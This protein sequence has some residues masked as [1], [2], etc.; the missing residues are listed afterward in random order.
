MTIRNKILIALICNDGELMSIGEFRK[1]FFKEYGEIVPYGTISGRCFEL[2]EE[3]Y[4]DKWEKWGHIKG[5]GYS[6]SEF[7]LL[8]K[9]KWIRKYFVDLI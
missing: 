2:T 1:L 8:G 4:L 9:K 7:V 6:I 5:H 3:G